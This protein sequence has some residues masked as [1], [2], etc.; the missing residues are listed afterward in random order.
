MIEKEF[1]ELVYAQAAQAGDAVPRG[2]VDRALTRHLERSGGR[3]YQAQAQDVVADARAFL[4]LADDTGSSFAIHAPG[5]GEVSGQLT[6]ALRGWVQ[7]WRERLG[8]RF[9]V[10]LPFADYTNAIEW[11]EGAAE[12]GEEFP[13]DD[14]DRMREAMSDDRVREFLGIRDPRTRVSIRSEQPSLAL[15]D[16]EN[17]V[18]RHIPPHPGGLLFALARE[19]ED[20][21]RR[22][23]FDEWRLLM[24]VLADI[25]PRLPAARIKTQ[26]FQAM[27]L[28]DGT[29]INGP[30]AVEVTFFTPDLTAQAL[31]EVYE[32]IKSRIWGVEEGALPTDR[33]RLVLEVVRELG[34]P[35]PNQWEEF[36]MKVGQRMSERTDGAITYTTPQ[37]PYRLWK[38]ATRR[39]APTGGQ[40]DG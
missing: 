37:G 14:R 34:K 33:Q 17:R 29:W 4:D 2:L 11:V 30:P 27:K 28:S 36:W 25:P 7:H 10:A 19:I 23:S 32:R 24:F 39:V 22:T 3:L 18:V 13:R 40:T 1:R 9:G 8:E 38:E 20:I 6:E 12:D 26:G 35:Q 15:P 21:A 16:F 5:V 31:Q